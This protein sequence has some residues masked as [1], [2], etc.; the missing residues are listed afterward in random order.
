MSRPKT[1]KISIQ[2]K[3]LS[4]EEAA[5]LYYSLFGG[6]ALIGSGCEDSTAVDSG[7]AP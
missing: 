6:P 4:H 2:T 7:L 3:G 5:L 1:H